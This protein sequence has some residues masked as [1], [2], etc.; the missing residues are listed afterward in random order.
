M[1]KNV[2]F[3]AKDMRILTT[4]VTFQSQITPRIIFYAEFLTRNVVQT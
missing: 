3:M 4:T 1:V 2:L